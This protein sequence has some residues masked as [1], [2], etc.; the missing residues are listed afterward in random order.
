VNIFIDCANYFAHGSIN[1][2]DVAILRATR[3]RLNDLFPHATVF[4]FTAAPEAI[5]C[6]VPGVV[7]VKVTD[8][9]VR[10]AD[11]IYARSVVNALKNADMVLLS[12]GGF[13]SD[14]FAS[15]AASLL[16]TLALAQARSIPTAIMFAGFEPVRNAAL[17]ATARSVLP[18]VDLVGCRESLVSPRVI[19]SFGVN[20]QNVAIG[21]DDAIEIACAVPPGDPGTMIGFVLRQSEYAG[22]DR[23]IVGRI[24]TAVVRAATRLR[25]E[26]V[27]LPTSLSLPSDFEASRDALATAHV[28]AAAPKSGSLESLFAAID[29]CRFVVTGA[30]H[31]GVFALSRGRPVIALAGNEH[32]SVKFRGLAA[33]FGVG[34]NVVDLDDEFEPK[35]VEAIAAAEEAAESLGRATTAVASEHSATQR[36]LWDRLRG[37]R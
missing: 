21:G 1:L 26:F 4:L 9:H 34:C 17:C 16:E 24:A 29:R 35:L 2:G 30:Y 10:D 25:R 20:A 6:L 14:H 12:G 27:V 7:P 28:S 13:F 15:H 22:V 23:T 3:N 32:Y 19:A 11:P 8:A 37:L 31:T 5:K 36:A 33:Y 18:K